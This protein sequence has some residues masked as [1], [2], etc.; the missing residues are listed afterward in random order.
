VSKP[1]KN[2]SNQTSDITGHS[3]IFFALWPNS[4]I[5]SR[6]EGIDKLLPQDQGRF[7]AVNNL[8]ITLSFIGE[9][10]QAQLQAY[11][12]AAGDINS[13]PFELVLDRLGYFARPRVLWLGGEHTP[14]SLLALVKRLNKALR[15]QGFK[16]ERR[17]F[18][19][20]VTLLRKAR[21]LSTLPEFEPVTWFVNEFALVQSSSKPTGV[22]YQVLQEYQFVC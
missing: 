19:P 7:V 22:S 12:Q 14:K 6:L 1:T 11:A 2:Q 9:V 18:K 21:P 10:D 5:R 15:K 4:E 20:H 16:P 13:E 17:P 3:R 8:H